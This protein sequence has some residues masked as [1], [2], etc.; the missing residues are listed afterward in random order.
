MTARPL[1]ATYRFQFS[2]DFTFDDARA[3]VPYLRDL[4][5]SHL[6]ASPIFHARPG[7]AH[8][9]D[10]IDHDAIN[11]ELGG[12]T[13]FRRL[14]ETL[15]D[16]GLG[17]I[18][19]IVPNHA[20]VGGMDNAR[21]RDVLEFGRRSRNARFFDIDWNAGPL[22]LPVLDAPVGEVVAEGRMKLVMDRREGR[23]MLAIGDQR[24]PLRPK[25]VSAVLTAA[26]EAAG[27]PALA[28]AGT[29]WA[30]LEGQRITAAVRKERRQAVAGELEDD[31]AFQAVERALAEADVAAAVADQHYQP[32]FWRDGATALNYRRFFDITD[33]AGLRV[34]EPTV[35]DAVH[36][37][38]IALVKE[39]LLDG[40]RVDHVDGLADPTAYCAH[41]RERVGGGVS[42][43][44]E[45]ILGLGEPLRHW[46]I[47]GTTGYETLN[48]INGLFVDPA[49]Y[50]AFTDHL[51]AC[52]IEGAPEERT[53]AAKR[54]VLERSFSSE[55]DVLCRWAPTSPGARAIRSA[56]APC[57]RSSSN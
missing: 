48:L 37:L 29:E 21:W 4:G 31:A 2:R 5:V 1:T 18:A 39:G 6:Y 56:S 57:A 24:L 12:E 8:G 38:P 54:E 10:V 25:T 9:Y 15:H 32:M 45:K 3:L 14:V 55:L 42:I 43:H 41:L 7:S 51:A 50:A 23:F 16:A 34:E 19:D 40:L 35:F 36:R 44:V 27:R 49:G 28:R 11:P 26:A 17:L 33:L 20:G 13:A 30:D 52:G 46:P 53:E 22:V 47:E